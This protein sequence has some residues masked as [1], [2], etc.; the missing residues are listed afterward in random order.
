MNGKTFERLMTV[1]AKK[2]KSDVCMICFGDFK[3]GS[4]NHPDHPLTMEMCEINCPNKCKFH[5]C[6]AKD[7]R[8]FDHKRDECPKCH[9]RVS[10][11]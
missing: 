6:C 1:M 8:S 4:Y 7:W 10:T 2:D 11:G 9:L 5:F 3:D